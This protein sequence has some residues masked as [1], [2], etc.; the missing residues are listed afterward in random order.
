MLEN[1]EKNF[2][3]IHLF[4]VH[5]KKPKIKIQKWFH[6]TQVSKKKIKYIV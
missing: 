4:I 2:A 6:S 3:H 5:F 1:I